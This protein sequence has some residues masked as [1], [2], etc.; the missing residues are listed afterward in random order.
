MT[1][2]DK[3]RILFIFSGLNRRRLLPQV[4]QGH[5]PTSAYRGML[6]LAKRDDVQV[7]FL[8]L[9]D[10]LGIP[11]WLSRNLPPTVLH[12]LHIPRI[13]QY[14]FAIASD[15]LPLGWA[16]S[17][18]HHLGGR[19]RWIYVPLNSS[20]LIRRHASHPMRLWGLKLIW[21]SF[22][23]IAYVTEGQREDLVRLGIK[24]AGLSCLPFGIDTHFFATPGEAEESGYVLSVGRD[25]GR[26]YPT[27]FAAA[28]Q[29]PYRF[30]VATAPKNIPEGVQIPPNVEIRYNVDAE[31]VRTLYHG[32]TCVAIL[33]KGD[34]TI[35]GSDCTGQTVMLEALSAGHAI[36]V[37]DRAWIRE[38]FADG[39]DYL[40]IP[41][42]DSAAAAVAIRKLWED[43]GFR[44]S[45]AEHG[46]EKV[47]ECYSSEIFAGGLL[48]IVREL[49][50]Y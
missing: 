6:E 19:T 38:Y 43:S 44:R 15:G 7:E 34:A 8:D 29:L 48:A 24:E 32:A 1:A 5:A 3:T 2:V 33:L 41:P 20:A 40:G 22:A 21:S 50:G 16:V 31:G 25:L 17:T 13:L 45:L 28:Q 30:I 23:R 27:L 26:D 11:G 4:Q 49:A 37:T 47:R 10:V 46:R 42:G 18:L 14:D 12:L 36:A 35:E 39:E 9:A